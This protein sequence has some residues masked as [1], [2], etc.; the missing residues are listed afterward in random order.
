MTYI[1]KIFLKSCLLL[2]TASYSQSAFCAPTEGVAVDLDGNG[3]PDFVITDT[4]IDSNGD[5][6]MIP[7]GST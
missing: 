4:V 6:I 7:Y 3:T 5:R 1:R 2:L